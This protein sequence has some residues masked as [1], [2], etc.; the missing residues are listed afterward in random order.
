M[1]VSLLL[2]VIKKLPRSLFHGQYSLPEDIYPPAMFRMRY[3]A[4]SAGTGA[5]YPGPFKSPAPVTG[6]RGGLGNQQLFR[7]SSMVSFWDNPLLLIPDT[8]PH[9][10]LDCWLHV[11]RVLWHLQLEI[12]AQNAKMINIGPTNGYFC[13]RSRNVPDLNV[14]SDLS[15]TSGCPDHSS[16]V[17]TGRSV[18]WA[19]STH[20]YTRL[21]VPTVR[22][23]PL[24]LIDRASIPFGLT[25][26]NE[27]N[28]W[29]FYKK[30]HC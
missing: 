23:W 27:H 28:V 11:S 2:Q 26:Q 16:S 4:A 1:S 20:P 15:W 5:Q 10:H 14:I 18:S 21:H 6:A 30:K 22:A 25:W 29:T 17:W 3:H 12:L 24:A 13:C 7:N 9:R 19:S 8:G